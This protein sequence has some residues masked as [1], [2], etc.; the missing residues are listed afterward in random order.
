MNKI[1]GAIMIVCMCTVGVAFA[2][3]T[4][5]NR[6]YPFS[7]S[8]LDC[9]YDVSAGNIIYI[10]CATPGALSTTARW[11][12][13]HLEYDVNND[14]TCIAHASGENAYSHIWTDRTTLTYKSNCFESE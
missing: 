3:L 5:G 9:L 7:Q 4:N 10:G 12:I 8:D 2:N 6:N 14:V 11:Q 13:K 1:I